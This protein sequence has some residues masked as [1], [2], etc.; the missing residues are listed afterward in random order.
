MKSNYI[1]GLN[2]KYQRILPFIHILPVLLL[3][4]PVLHVASEKKTV[5]GFGV[6]FETA[7]RASG[8]TAASGYLYL[9]FLIMP[10]ILFIFGLL[11]FVRPSVRLVKTAIVMQVLYSL[12]LL[13][14]LFTSKKII[15]A[16]GYLNAP[17]LIRY[18]G[19]GYWIML[20]AGFAGMI[21]TM[22]A[23]KISPGYIVLTLMSVIW[24]FPIFWIVLTSL[25]AEKGFYVG[26]LIP[27]DFTLRN[28]INLFDESTENNIIHFKTWW[29]NTFWISAAIC[30]INTIIVVATAYVLSRHRFRG[31]RSFM[32]A[33][34]II[35]MF[36]GFMSMIAVYNILKGIGLAQQLVAL[37]IVSAAGAAMGYYVCKGFFDT[38]SKSLDEAALIDGATRFQIFRKIILPLS[39]PVII[40]TTLSSFIGP[41]GDYIFPSLLIGDNK[42]KATVAIGLK[43]LID[44]QRINDYY[45]QFAA[46]AVVVSIPIVIL[47]ICMQKFYVEGLSGSVKG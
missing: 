16:S 11:I 17:F 30:V 12:C 20:L 34:L 6:L 25:R 36:P 7:K 4:L 35:G 10:V 38:I 19:F 8:L 31:R 3:F 29:L 24:L 14:V 45:T 47:F 40:Y 2:P 23:A 13:L 27:K 32:N 28:Y 41:W 21:L 44:K 42:Q 33:V 9:T 5:S 22:K 26:Y 46:G 1:I 43:W 18:L 15:D 39:K 37:V